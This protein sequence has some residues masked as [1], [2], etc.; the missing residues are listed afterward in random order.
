MKVDLVLSRLKARPDLPPFQVLH[1]PEVDSTNT[2]LLEAAGG[3]GPLDSAWTVLVAD[4]Q[5]KGMG[6]KGRGWECP[7]REG[8]LLSLRLDLSLSTHAL[9][10]VGHWAA[11]ALCRAIE[12]VLGEGAARVWWKWP[13][14]IFLEDDTGR[15]KVAGILVQSQVQGDLAR[16]VLG[17]GVNLGQAAFP[18]GLR[19]PAR[20][21]MQAGCRV[22]QEDL[23]ARILLHL[24]DS[25]APRR[26]AGLPGALLSR[27]LLAS[28]PAFLC[29]GGERSPL[30]HE[31]EADGPLRVLSRGGPVLLAGGGLIIERL[32]REELWC[33]LEA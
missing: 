10:M 31:H 13:N 16:V 32:T 4:R 25:G 6:S 19:Q 2:R 33:S 11:L 27:D 14:D 5:R 20:S 18:D 3:G 26:S 24:A 23:L 22:T 7:D 8:L 17:M 9:S 29:E 1:R 15:G 21:L 28:R 12:E 30:R